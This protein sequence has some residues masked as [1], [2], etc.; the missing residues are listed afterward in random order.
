[1]DQQ[2]ASPLESAFE[3]G[4]ASH[5][6]ICL[7]NKP[8]RFPCWFGNRIA[9]P[10]AKCVILVLAG[11]RISVEETNTETLVWL[12]IGA[13]VRKITGRWKFDMETVTMDIVHELLVTVYSCEPVC[14]VT[15]E[16]GV[17]FSLLDE[18]KEDVL[19]LKEYDLNLVEKVDTTDLYDYHM[20]GAIASG[21]PEWAKW[22]VEQGK[23]I[24]TSAHL[25][26]AAANGFFGASEVLIN[27][28]ARTSQYPSNRWPWCVRNTES[29]IARVHERVYSAITVVWYSG[30]KIPAEM[31]AMIIKHVW[32]TRYDLAIWNGE[33]D[34]NVQTAHAMDVLNIG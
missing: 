27:A 29:R 1:M 16:V 5:L 13:I 28:G 25:L 2:E 18:L 7:Q 19:R 14:D 11:A 12:Q 30:W 20:H 10:E 34:W 15:C 4:S 24:P 9:E 21:E 3:R 32:A 33:R 6:L 22:L 17:P 23:V 8:L 26:F 31:L